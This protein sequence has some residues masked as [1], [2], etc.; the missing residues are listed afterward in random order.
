MQ[1]DGSYDCPYCLQT[2]LKDGALRCPLCRSEITIDYW[3]AA[4][5]K[6]KADDEA[7]IA[8]LALQR[9]LYEE[10]AVLRETAEQAASAEGRRVQKQKEKRELVFQGCLLGPFYGGVLLGFA[11]CV[12]CFP[13]GPTMS[14][15]SFNLFTGA[16]YGALIGAV[17]GP[18]IG[19]AIASVK[20]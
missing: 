1:I 18:M 13:N 4:R 9:A 5:A 11:G 3:Q 6:R 2:S 8:A 14:T 15:T 10:A 7:R 19:L 20:N 12:S 16:F 17:V